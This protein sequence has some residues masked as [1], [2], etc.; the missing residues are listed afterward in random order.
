MA[1]VG[2]R[3]SAA[4]RAIAVVAVLA[5]LLALI[6]TS[7]PANRD[8]IPG[9]LAAAKE[10]TQSAVRSAALA[11]RLFSDDRATSALTSVQ[12]TDMR[13]Q[14]IKAYKEIASLKADDENDLKRQRVLTTAMT[15]FVDE[16]NTAA[17]AV[18][19]PHRP[20][21]LPLRQRLLDG[22]DTLERDYAR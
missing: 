20:D 16:L 18:R 11:V 4:G 5:G 21:L 19:A 15:A 8:G 3:V 10:E 14:I 17:A 12:I 13:D 2:N 22:V 1:R 9:Q 6:L 7:C